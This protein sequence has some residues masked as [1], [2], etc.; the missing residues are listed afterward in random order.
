LS[1]AL[2]IDHLRRGALD[3]V[4]P[5]LRG[6]FALWMDSVVAAELRQDASAFAR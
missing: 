3:A 1:S 6:R 5:A 4:I 2:S